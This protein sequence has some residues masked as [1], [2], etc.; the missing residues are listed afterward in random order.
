MP[1]AWDRERL[2]DAALAWR[3]V[4]LDADVV[5]ATNFPSY[6]ARHPRK[7]LWLAHQH[8]GAYD[9]IDQPWSDL[10]GDEAGLE[11]QRQL[12]EWDTRAHRRG[13]AP[14]HDRPGRVASAWPGTAASTARRCTTRRRWPTG[15]R[16]VRSGTTSSASTG[17]RP[18]SGP[19]SWSAGCWRRGAA[20]EASWPAPVRCARQLE[21]AID[22][23][24]GGG[25]VELPGFVADDELVPLL[26]GCL[27]V[28]YAPYDEDYGYVTLQAFLGRQARHH[29]DRRRRRPRLGRARRHRASSPS[30]RPRR[31]ARRSTAWPA[32]PP[33]PPGSG[34]AGRARA[35]ALDWKTVVDTLLRDER[36]TRPLL[37]VKAAGAVTAT[38]PLRAL[39]RALADTVDVRA[40]LRCRRR[41]DAVL[42][43]GRSGA[44]GAA[45]G[46]AGG[47]VGRIGRGGTDLP[48]RVVAVG[49]RPGPDGV[50][51]ARAP[52][53]RGPLAA[54]RTGRAAALAAAPRPA[55]RVGGAGRVGAAGGPADRAGAVRVRGRLRRPPPRPR[56]GHAGG[57]RAP[58]RQPRSVPATRCWCPRRATTSPRWPPSW[59]P[60]RCG[61]RGSHGWPEPERSATSTSAVRPASCSSGSASSPRRPGPPI[62]S[63]R[64]S[65]SW[66]AAPATASPIA[67]TVAVARAGGRHEPSGDRRPLG[68]AP[69]KL[70]GDGGHRRGPE[71]EPPAPRPGRRRRPGGPPPRSSP[72]C[73]R[74]RPRRSTPSCRWPDARSRPSAPTS[75]APAPSSK[76][77]SSSSAP[78]STPATEG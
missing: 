25:R 52:G 27:G 46:H 34:A 26:A 50:D 78:S 71:D 51:G 75:T 39:L 31:S 35:A 59:R 47:A 66:A 43:T 7:V 40:L 19:T 62:A 11:V 24:G 72:G 22:A 16:P 28:I 68:G 9:G 8:R 74:P 54:D 65:R 76:P 10:G 63:R 36:V 67:W 30:R 53:G 37:A 4:P 17:W 45:R 41:P 18:T 15:S 3:M 29:H 33:W 57:H 56:A 55:R 42:V 49:H 1:A 14:L 21:A 48:G 44:A 58:S 32:T 60:T 73:A 6:F 13:V 5:I 2:L 64:T 38:P 70:A 12:T 77:R 69:A 61:R 20:C 23:A